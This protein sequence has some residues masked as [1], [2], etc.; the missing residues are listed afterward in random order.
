MAF[1]WVGC[2]SE[3]GWRVLHQFLDPED[4]R[5][6]DPKEAERNM[7]H[8]A[9]LIQQGQNSEA[10]HLCTALEESGSV[11]RQSLET[12]VHRLYQKTL[13]SRSPFL[14]DIRLW[15]E[16]G[17]F[18]E[19]ESQL[20]QLLTRQPDNWAATLLL[21]RVY[22][23]DLGQPNRA[24]A[25]I[26]PAYKP[27]VLPQQFLKLARQSI[28]EWSDSASK[29]AQLARRSQHDNF[30]SEPQPEPVPEISIDELLKSGQ[31]A[32]AIEH[33]ENALKEQPH[34]AELWLKLAEAHSVY[35]AD[36]AQAAKV[37]RRMAITSRFTPEELE[38]AR[39]KLKEWQA[40]RRS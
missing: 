17:H 39:A 13:D 26:Q 8:L 16:R 28:T 12:T 18:A 40:A 34:D 6:F 10:L 37:I 19:A 27:P 7:D 20:Q 22:A 38:S 4:K 5:P 25:L 14:K 2:L 24:L 32:T 35:C 29:R 36:E 11:S 21:A 33:M 15:R 23:E 9:G 1:M 31:L 30:R 3:F